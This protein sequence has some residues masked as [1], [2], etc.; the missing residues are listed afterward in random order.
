MPGIAKAHDVD[1]GA[2]LGRVDRLLVESCGA[3]EGIVVGHRKIS[4]PA[5][6]ARNVSISV[7]LEVA[8]FLVDVD[9]ND[10][11]IEVFVDSLGV[12]VILVLASLVA[13]GDVQV[14]IRTKPATV[15]VVVWTIENLVDQDAF[16]CW[17]G[18]LGIKS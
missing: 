4:V 1:F 18:H 17:I 12:L 15:N 14:A 5:T 3:N 13:E 16:R 2:H 9:A 11:R 7:R 8:G 10:G 6:I